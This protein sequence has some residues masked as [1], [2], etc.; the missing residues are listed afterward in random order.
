[1]LPFFLSTI[2]VLMPGN[3]LI[4]ATQ[5][6]YWKYLFFCIT[7]RVFISVYKNSSEAF[8]NGFFTEITRL[9]LLNV[10]LLH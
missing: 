7:N 5:D 10:S 8:R 9:R 1:M 6:V 3:L 2:E 4:L